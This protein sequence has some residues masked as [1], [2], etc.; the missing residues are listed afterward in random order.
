MVK[1]GVLYGGRESYHHMCRYFSGFFFRQI[2]KETL[3]MNL[4]PAAN[5]KAPHM[6]ALLLY[7]SPPMRAP[8]NRARIENSR[9]SCRLK[10]V[11][12]KSLMLVLFFHV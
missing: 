5:H 7:I 6:P 9:F 4:R 1:S 10:R 2:M 8:Q 12:T 3:M 11:M